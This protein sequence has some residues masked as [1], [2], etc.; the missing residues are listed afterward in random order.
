[1]LQECAVRLAAHAAAH[2][3]GAPP[4]PV[5][6]S[7]PGRMSASGPL[8][9]AC[10]LGGCG[11]LAGGLP[12][13]GFSGA[14]PANLAGG[15][16]DERNQLFD[17]YASCVASAEPRFTLVE[18]VPAFCGSGYAI[19]LGRRLLMMRYQ[20][21]VVVLQAGNFGAPQSRVR[22]FVVGA[23]FGSALPEPPRPTHDFR[24]IGDSGRRKSGKPCPW[25]RENL[26][27][28]IPGFDVALGKFKGCC[29]TVKPAEGARLA[30]R[31]TVHD[32]IGDLPAASWRSA[33]A[34]HPGAPPG[35]RHHW[36]APLGPADAARAAELAPGANGSSLRR[37][38]LP[39]APR[40]K[41]S[42]GGGEPAQPSCHSR[43]YARLAWDGVFNT[44]T[45][46]VPDMSTG[47]WLH[48]SADRLVTVREAAD[49][50]TF[51]RAF[52][53]HVARPE[54]TAKARGGR[55]GGGLS[56]LEA[57][58]LKAQFRMIGNAVPPVVGEAWGRSILAAA[59]KGRFRTPPQH[60]HAS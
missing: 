39:P 40:T 15:F 53:F 47:R 35:L 28:G 54:K 4:A 18:E 17:T 49:A 55:G 20:V 60:A 37:E 2:R 30:P 22:A 6:L 31:R 1:M 38:L 50:Q 41:R 43:N 7:S 5:H 46:Q 57:A 32:A 42:S 27:S 59:L 16:E 34:E 21:R 26:Y 33:E 25:T 29:V 24:P 14:N 52:T 13:Q 8:H 51:D 58:T 45:A 44:I 36:C 12:C 19:L 3:A 48:P 9:R 23:E 56:A 11:L 10:L